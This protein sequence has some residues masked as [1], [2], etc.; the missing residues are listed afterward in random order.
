MKEMEE[1]SPFQ[2]DTQNT[3]SAMRHLNMEKNV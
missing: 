1:W 2:E 3:V